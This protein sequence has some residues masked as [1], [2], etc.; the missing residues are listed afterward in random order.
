MELMKKFSD[1]PLIKYLSNAE[2]ERLMSST[3]SRILQPGENLIRQG[4]VDYRMFFIESGYLDVIDERLGSDAVIASLTS[5]DVLGEMAF[6]NEAPRSATVKA[7]V[8][9]VVKELS[10]DN[11]REIAD[12]DPILFGKFMLALS[13]ILSERMRA[14]L[15]TLPNLVARLHQLHAHPENEKTNDFSE[16]EDGLQSVNRWLRRSL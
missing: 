4:E 7:K 11:I 8:I 2:K 9:T 3:R 1:E 16:I 5:G 12:S 14:T 6:L 13:E 10:R 15:D